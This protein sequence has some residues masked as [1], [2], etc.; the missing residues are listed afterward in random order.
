MMKEIKINEIKNLVAEDYLEDALKMLLGI[1]WI[2]PFSNDIILLSARHKDLQKQ[3]QRGSIT[4]EQA[5]LEKNNI[6]YGLLGLLQEVSGT[7][8]SNSISKIE[9]LLKRLSL[10]NGILFRLIHTT[11]QIHKAAKILKLWFKTIRIYAKGGYFNLSD[12]RK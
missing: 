8:K 4:F 3:I 10:L 6:R 12:N 11:I 2:K 7:P 1:D 9:L 5:I